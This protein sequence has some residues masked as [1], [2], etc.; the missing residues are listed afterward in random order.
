MSEGFRC[1]LR[2]EGM[3]R[4]WV[5]MKQSTLGSIHLLQPLFLNI[6]VLLMLLHQRRISIYSFTTTQEN[7]SSFL[8]NFHTHFEEHIIIYLRNMIISLKPSMFLLLI[9]LSSNLPRSLSFYHSSFYNTYYEGFWMLQ[10][11]YHEFPWGTAG[12]GSR[13]I[14]AA[15]QAAAMA[16][17][18]SLA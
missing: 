11:F 12:Q 15:A 4:G 7:M 2:H 3:V 16:W 8:V 5:P 14:T 1:G 17:V 6:Q 13:V 9:L 18:P 10:K